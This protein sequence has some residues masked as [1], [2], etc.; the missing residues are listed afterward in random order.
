MKHEIEKILTETFPKAKLISV[1]TLGRKFVALF[2][3]DA[4]KCESRS[5]AKA[6]KALAKIGASNIAIDAESELVSVLSGEFS[7]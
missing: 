4:F 7:A 2:K 1:H 3:A 5:R 6:Q